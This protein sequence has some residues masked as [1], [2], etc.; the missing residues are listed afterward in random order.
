MWIIG[1]SYERIQEMAVIYDS[2]RYLCFSQY[3]VVEPVNRSQIDM[4]RKTCDIRTWG[5]KKILGISSTN[6]DALLPSLYQCVETH[7]TDLF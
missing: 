5:G 1:G 6:I 3:Y 4:K 7:S 2:E